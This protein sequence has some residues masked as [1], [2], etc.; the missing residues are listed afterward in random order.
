M[1]STQNCSV[2]RRH[3]SRYICAHSSR[4]T[5]STLRAF[6]VDPAGLATW[7]GARLLLR[8]R[9]RE[10]RRARRSRANDLARDRSACV[11]RRRAESRR[12]RDAIVAERCCSKSYASRVPESSVSWSSRRDGLIPLTGKRVNSTR[13]RTATIWPYSPSSTGKP[14]MRPWMPSKSISTSAGLS[15]FFS[16]S[17]S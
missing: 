16:S 13:S 1:S 17:R 4:G 6:E 2:C 9:L 14:R 15:G 10:G 3:A 7:V 11:R 8:R 12:T 5:I